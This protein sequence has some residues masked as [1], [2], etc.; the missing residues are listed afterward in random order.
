[1]SQAFDFEAFL[2]KLEELAG[3]S[4]CL[5]DFA[6]M[7]E[8][9]GLEIP[10]RRQTHC[11]A[12]CEAVK[13]SCHKRCVEEDN[14]R[15]QRALEKGQ[16]IVDTCYAGMTE[17]IVPIAIA[18]KPQ[19]ALFIGQAN[20][21]SAR[22]AERKQTAIADRKTRRKDQ[23]AA[24]FAK[25]PRLTRKQLD[26]LKPIG[27][28]IVELVR[29]DW[30]S[31]RAGPGPR[32]GPEELGDGSGLLPA[33]AQIPIVRRTVPRTEGIA[34]AIEWMGEAFAT[35]ASIEK[36]AKV[37]GVSVSTFSRKFRRETGCTYRK[38]LQI[39]RVQAASFLL[40]RSDM[41]VSEIAYAVGY[42]NAPSFN[43]A[44]GQIERTTPVAHIRRNID[45]GGGAALPERKP[46]GNS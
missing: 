20:S 45:W 9:S 35:E 28:G 3:C 2:A 11:S 26:S 18:G 42:Q 30:E 23:L 14:R 8:G 43:R 32:R 40:K 38:F 41:T 17:L 12:Y 19:G 13:R 39:I 5:Y 7:S 36:A 27:D 10:Y 4:I 29:K 34:K 33:G 31:N 25:A 24:A 15:A 1:M 37:A 22:T 16:P 21:L 46:Q 6:L 44:F